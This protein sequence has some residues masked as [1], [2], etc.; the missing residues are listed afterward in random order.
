MVKLD[1]L[2]G[3]SRKRNR[4]SMYVNQA[5]GREGQKAGSLMSR[6]GC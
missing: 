2:I 1:L 4:L 5:L 3:N 6:D